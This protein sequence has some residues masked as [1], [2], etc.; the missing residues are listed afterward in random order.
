ME[1][2][3]Q[4]IEAVCLYTLLN[5]KVSLPLPYGEPSAGIS[6][7]SRRILLTRSSMRGAS[8]SGGEKLARMRSESCCEELIARGEKNVPAME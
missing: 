7:Y 5:P 8:T 1:Q 6:G 4:Q 3:T 2:V